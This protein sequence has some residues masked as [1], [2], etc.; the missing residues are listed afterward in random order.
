MC[1]S[2]L[3]TEDVMTAMH[4]EDDASSMTSMDHGGVHNTI[5]TAAFLA[6][7]KSQHGQK[8]AGTGC[9]NNLVAVIFKCCCPLLSGAPHAPCEMEWRQSKGIEV[10]RW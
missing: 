10:E 1:T 4:L 5:V 7:Y 6:D 2:S 3:V 9:T 8:T